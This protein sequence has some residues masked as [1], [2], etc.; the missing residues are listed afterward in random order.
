MLVHANV[1]KG[2]PFAD[3]SGTGPCPCKPMHEPMQT[4]DIAKRICLADQFGT[5]MAIVRSDI[6]GNI[7]RLSAAWSKNPEKFTNLYEIVLDEVA[8]KQENRSTSDTKGLLWLKRCGTSISQTDFG[9][10][11]AM[12]DMQD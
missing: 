12:G 6:K 8:R 4:A 1:G 5:G 11:P 2:N 7:D 9:L 3:H 10:L